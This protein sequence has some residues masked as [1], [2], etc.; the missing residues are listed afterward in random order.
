MLKR[1]IT[2]VL[3]ST[4]VG[5]RGQH[6]SVPSIMK[7]TYSRKTAE[8]LA[9]AAW[10]KL[11]NDTHRHAAVK[12][13]TASPRMMSITRGIGWSGTMHSPRQSCH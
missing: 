1:Q 3:V 11:Q 7:R 9:Q 5:M 13:G 4:P 2:V 12:H 8:G 10:V 6:S